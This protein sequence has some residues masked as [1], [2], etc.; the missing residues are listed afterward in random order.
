[1]TTS[2]GNMMKFANM[3]D[4]YPNWITLKNGNI[5]GHPF[6]PLLWL[7]E[8]EWGL[9]GI[10]LFSHE[11][12]S[13]Y[14]AHQHHQYIFTTTHSCDK[15]LILYSDTHLVHPYFNFNPPNSCFFFCETPSTLIYQ[16]KHLAKTCFIKQT[17]WLICSSFMESIYMYMYIP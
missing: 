13:P 16:K 7:W 5:G 4:M 8:E 2:N 6:F 9:L 1:M 14:E 11:N 10:L 15:F 3:E 12:T 17:K